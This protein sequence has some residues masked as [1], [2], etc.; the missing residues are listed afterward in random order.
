LFQGLE[1]G[2]RP[3][4]YRQEQRLLYNKF[5][6]PGDI[7]VTPYVLLK[8]AIRELQRL[9]A[10]LKDREI[11]IMDVLPRFM[12]VFCC[13]KVE[14]CAKIRLQGP[15]GTTAGK[16][17]LE[18]LAELNAELAAHLTGPGVKLISTGDLLTG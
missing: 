8:L 3:Q 5:H 7:A 2:G 15:E 14:H 13:E 6:V 11:W 12:L 9:L 1:P 16:R 10:S 4:P 17:L 18:E